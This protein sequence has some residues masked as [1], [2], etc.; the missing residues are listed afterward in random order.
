MRHIGHKVAAHGLGLLHRSDIAREQQTAAV[1]IRV[2]V[3]RQAHRLGC[4]AGAPWH[5]HIALKVSR[6]QVGGKAR[7]AHQIAKVLE[8]IPRSFQAEMRLGRLVEPLNAQ[9]VVQ[10]HHAIGRGLHGGQKVLKAAVTLLNGTL[11]RAG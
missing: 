7:V 2:H 5:E 9:I 8:Q 1:A 6:G 11:A 3:H 10:Q 4:G